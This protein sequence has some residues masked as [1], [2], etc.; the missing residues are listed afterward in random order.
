[1]AKKNTKNLPID[2][3][4]NVC[5]NCWG[6]YEYADKIRKDIYE[7]EIAVNNHEKVRS[8]IV[9]WV[10]KNLEGIHLKKE[11]D[12]LVCTHCNTRYSNPN[13]PGG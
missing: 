10:K 2:K 13:L 6:Y 9:D 8:F 7:E 1:M 11:K 5:P 3:P 4:E 12:E